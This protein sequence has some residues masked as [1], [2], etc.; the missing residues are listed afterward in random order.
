MR[1]KRTGP[2]RRSV[3]RTSSRLLGRCD[4]RLPPLSWPR[5]PRFKGTV[6]EVGELAGAKRRE[7]D[8]ASDLLRKLDVVGCGTRS[9]IKAYDTCVNRTVV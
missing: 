6:A 8:R 1:W 7:G 5:M 2:L 4:R 9:L 3:R